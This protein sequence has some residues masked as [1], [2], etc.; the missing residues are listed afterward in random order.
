MTDLRGPFSTLARHI[1]D[2]DPSTDHIFIARFEMGENDKGEDEIN[3]NVTDSY[4]Q[5]VSITLSADGTWSLVFIG[6]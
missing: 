1:C 3:V 5:G 2:V 4:H 6:G